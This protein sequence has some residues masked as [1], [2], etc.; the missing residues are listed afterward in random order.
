MFCPNCGSMNQDG[1]RFCQKCGKQLAQNTGYPPPGAPPA[2]GPGQTQ[3]P[4]A[5]IGYSPPNTGFTPPNTVVIP[6]NQGFRAGPNTGYIPPTQGFTP[7]GAGFTPPPTGYTQGPPGGFA[8][9]KRNTGLIAAIIVLV[10]V[11]IAV[12]LII[13]A[14]NN[15]QKNDPTLSSPVITSADVSADIPSPDISNPDVSAGIAED[16]FRNNYTTILGGGQ[17]TVTVMLYICGADL[18]SYSGCA[19]DDIQEMLD[20]SFGSNVN[21]VLQTG[22]CKSWFTP[23][24]KDGEVQRWVIQDGELIELQELGRLPLLDEGTLTDFITFAASEYPANRYGFIFWDHGGGSVYGYGQDEVY[25]KTGLYLPNIASGL[26][27]SGVK[28]DF[29][30]FDACLMATIET[31]Y[32]LEPYADYLIASEETEPGDGWFYTP[33]LTTLG[34]NT[35]IDTVELGAAIADSFIADNAPYGHEKGEPDCTLSVVALREIP[36][37]YEQL[38]N[39]MSNA[40]A[41]VISTSEQF[42]K[43]STAVSRTRSF[44]DGG[45]DMIDMGDFAKRSNLEGK[46]ELTAAILSAVKYSNT[47]AHNGVCGLSF[48]FPYYDLSIYDIAKDMF[49]QIGYGDEIYDFY[50]TFINIVAGGQNSTSRS[51]MENLTGVAEAQTDYSSFNWYNSSE[52]ENYTYDSIDF[53]ELQLVQDA[54]TG[55]WYLPL[56]SNEWSLL[57]EVQMQILVDDGEGYIDLGSDQYFET[58]DYGNLLFNFNNDNT[59]VAIGGQIVCYYAES[60]TQMDDGTNVFLGYVPAVLNGETEIHIMCK[61][62]G[63]DPDGIILGYR[64]A[65][66]EDTAAFGQGTIG[67]GYLALKPGDT[68]DFICDYYTYDGSFD[69]SYYFGDTMIL[70]DTL[71]EVTYE[72]IGSNTVLECYMLVDIYQNYSWTEYVEFTAG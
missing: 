14:I 1:T 35:S 47:T 67:K 26:R 58:D 65:N 72:D 5:N 52:V 71:P 41:A 56:T 69:D 17:D 21:L 49:D 25:P 50:D 10:L 68:L 70:G 22:G 64:V 12:P 57:T 30:G 27:S 42:K 28:F 48:Y 31:A 37:V 59:W 40:T 19:S 20:A 2:H 54:S 34:E 63:D 44:A 15:G 66:T 3:G 18:E 39:Y 7:P 55:Q 29:V 45:V 53:T 36:Y 62:V 43:I 23:G 11:V 13:V 60:T 32:M 51:L 9:K 46:D 4:G 6:P 24:M 16:G 61:W 8:P 33:W 38:C